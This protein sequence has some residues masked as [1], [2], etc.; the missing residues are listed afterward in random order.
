MTDQDFTTIY[1]ITLEA[2]KRIGTMIASTPTGRRGMFYKTCTE[3]KFNQD[4]AIPPVNTKQLGY[5][6][7]SKKYDRE[8]AEGW[9][10]FHYPSMCN[11]EW[12]EQ[13][14]REL[15]NQFDE[16]SYEHEVLAEFGTET[17]GVFNKDYIDEAASKG[18]RLQER[19][20]SNA[21]V[22][23]GIDWDKYGS[24]TNIVVVQY[25][26][27]DQQRARP[28]LGIM[29]PEFGRFKVI[30]HIEIPKS[31]MH[32]DM[33]VQTVIELDK[34]Y[35]PFAIYPDRGAGEYQIEMLRK[36]LGD[37]V[38][39]VFY[40]STTE[41]RDPISRV[42][43]KKSLKPFLV[44]QTTLMLE[45][46]QLRI[47]H[48]DISE[49]IHRQMTNFQVVRVSEKSQEPVYTSEDEHGLD[50][51]IFALYAFIEEYPDLVNT[52]YRI[53]TARQMGVQKPIHHDPLN[54]IIQNRLDGNREIE[55][56]DEPG[57]PPLR[58]VRVG[59]AGK[60]SSQNELG[61]GRRGQSLGRKPVK[62]R[63]F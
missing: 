21:P 62:R 35:H 9:K 14:E 36:A 24:Q 63:G 13:M 37:K 3:M 1:A 15:K 45:R 23:I 43:E 42:F 22:A 58:K 20:A 19:S 55:A 5:V 25:D 29:E 17:I 27:F 33:A 18:Y 10:E 50:A 28:E 46:G 52:I 12:S 56:W 61:W 8:L 49:V 31:E 39:G 16:I 11:P 2:P 53:E 60:K 41:V 26:P 32:Y 57:G 48:K 7:D 6:Y 40:G 51:M 54:A 47:P 34:K 4:E 38:K 30:N 44:N 59:Y